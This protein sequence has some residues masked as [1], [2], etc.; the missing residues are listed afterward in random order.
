MLAQKLQETV[1]LGGVQIL[2]Q[3]GLNPELPLT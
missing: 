2:L 3:G 1:D